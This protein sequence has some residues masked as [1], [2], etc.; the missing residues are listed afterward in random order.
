MAR[1]GL[2]GQV[3]RDPRSGSGFDLVRNARVGVGGTVALLNF[4]GHEH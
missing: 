4:A 3:M 2:M 1:E